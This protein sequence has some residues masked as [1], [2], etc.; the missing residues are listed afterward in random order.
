VGSQ[1]LTAWAMARPT[2]TLSRTIM[3]YRSLLCLCRVPSVRER[4]VKLQTLPCLF[5]SPYDNQLAG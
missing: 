3:Q 2:A 5:K 1:R 4:R